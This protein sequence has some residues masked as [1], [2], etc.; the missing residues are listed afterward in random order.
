MLNKNN[1][2]I[3]GNIGNIKH[4]DL[5]NKETGEITKV[6]RIGV[7]TNREYKKDDK[8][9]KEVEWHSVVCWQWRSDVIRKF[10]LVG[11]TVLIDG[12]MTYRKYTDSENVKRIKAEIICEKIIVFDKVT[13]RKKEPEPEPKEKTKKNNK[14]NGK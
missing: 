4:T 7:A 5:I 1:I 2:T 6:S 8:T 10:C 14:K 12:R 13:A 11:N 3:V 9:I